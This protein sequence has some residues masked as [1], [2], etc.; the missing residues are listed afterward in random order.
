MKSG[1]PPPA[2][3]EAAP[4]LDESYRHRD[5]SRLSSYGWWK[6]TIRPTVFPIMGFVF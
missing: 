3:A 4:A 6:I 1:P 2:A 5:G